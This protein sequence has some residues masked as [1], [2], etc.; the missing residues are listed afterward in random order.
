MTFTIE[1]TN[2]T[3]RATFIRVAQQYHQLGFQMALA[4]SGWDI[5]YTDACAVIAEVDMIKFTMD[6]PGP[7]GYTPAQ[8]TKVSEWRNLAASHD[9][10]F[11]MHGIDSDTDLKLARGLGIQY[12]QGYYF[13]RSVLPR[14]V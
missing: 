5:S 8:Y 4:N 12:G 13:S 14:I 10:P 2:I 9:I 7:D 1:I 6:Q 11:I 3:D